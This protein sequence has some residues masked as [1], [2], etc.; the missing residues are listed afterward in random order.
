MLSQCAGVAQGPDVRKR[1]SSYDTFAIIEKTPQLF[2]LA[3]DE[4]GHG[5]NNAE[6]L[7][8]ARH[9]A[10]TRPANTSILRSATG[11]LWPNT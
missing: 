3:E 9:G 11:G 2:E 7:A 5:S 10:L 1:C 4:D 6:M 8:G